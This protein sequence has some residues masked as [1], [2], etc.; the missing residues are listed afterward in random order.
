MSPSPL[1]DLD[2][3]PEDMIRR[4]CVKVSIIKAALL[5]RLPARAPVPEVVTLDFRAQLSRFHAQLPEWMTAAKLLGN[6]GG[7][8][9]ITF[10]PVIF[11]VH[12]FYLSAMMLLARRLIIAYI[13]LDV[14]G[15]VDFP[16]E[17]QRAV[18][19]GY[20]AAQMN[21]SVMNIMLQEGK[22]VQV[23]WLCIYTAYT[24]GVMIAHKATQKALHGISSVDNIELL[25]KCVDVLDY[26]AQKDALA[27]KFRSLLTAQMD[28]FQQHDLSGSGFQDTSADDGLPV[29]IYLPNV[30]AGSS[31]LHKAASYLLQII[32]RPFSGL[33]DVLAQKTLSNR[34]ESTM[35]THLEWEY[36]IKEG[37]CVDNTVGEE[38]MAGLADALGE[39]GDIPRT[40]SEQGA[41]MQQFLGEPGPSAW[42][43]GGA[44]AVGTCVGKA[45]LESGGDVVFLDIIPEPN[46]ETWETILETARA[47]NTHA[48]Y[49][50][51][52]IQDEPSITT[53]FTALLPILHHP[54][55]GLVHCAAISGES[56]ACTYPTAT[57]RRILDVNLTG[58]FLIAR[59]VASQLH[60]TQ[61]TGSIVLIASISGHVSNRGINTAAY[62]A[63]KA[64]VHQ[65]C[66]SLAAE[67]GHPQ[68]TFPG[69]T[70]S[71]TNPEGGVMG[72]REVYPPIRVNSVS[73]GHI[74]TA[75]SRAARERGLTDEWARQNML[76]RISVVEE[77][78]APVLFLLGEGSSYVTGSVSIWGHGLGDLGAVLMWGF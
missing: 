44:G 5:H 58:T 46:P 12:L 17:A 56:D 66:R 25:N 76:G 71:E 48:F 43:S 14:P 16:P 72:A 37:N 54:I 65:L 78:R 57:F 67:W 74:D 49:H 13:P 24:V 70:V 21:A 32:H 51:L 35:G 28:I 19:E 60:R 39:A 69:S 62:N 36:E 4:E 61:Q 55:R 68:N 33:D 6:T 52:N 31:P 64:G 34:A 11:Y 18:E 9:M 3:P 59:A 23:C 63:S 7:D 22:V 75:L 47:N 10:R 50:T 53:A 15:K 38:E 45:I 40:I 30:P 26:C 8:L 29:H 73:P 77:F 41:S 20:H 2:V 1:D 42:I 27:V